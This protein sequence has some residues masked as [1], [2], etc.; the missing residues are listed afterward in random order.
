MYAVA[1][2]RPVVI[3]VLMAG[4]FVLGTGSASAQDGYEDETGEP[5]M[6]ATTSEDSLT[7][8]GPHQL[9]APADDRVVADT[10]SVASPR[11]AAAIPLGLAVLLLSVGGFAAMVTSIRASGR[12]VAPSS[13]A[14]TSQVTPAPSPRMME[15]T[16]ARRSAPAPAR[17][18]GP[19]L[20]WRTD[21][22]AVGR[23]SFTVLFVSTSNH[24][25]SNLAARTARE[26]I[27]SRFGDSL[28]QGFRISSAGTRANSA[29]PPHPSVMAE[30]AEPGSGAVS[31]QPAIQLTADM[32]EAADLV[33][34]ATR[35]HRTEV[36]RLR[37]SALGKTF[38]LVEYARLMAVVD[39]ES[40]P[41]DPFD[42]ARAAVSAAREKRGLIPPVPRADDDIADPL[43]SGRAGQRACASAIAT[44]LSAIVWLEPSPEGR[45][46]SQMRSTAKNRCRGNRCTSCGPRNGTGCSRVDRSSISTL[47][48]TGD[49][50]RRQR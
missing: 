31:R 27:R 21:Q 6:I 43:G 47:T 12:K 24:Y 7:V 41:V 46:W 1:F 35:K 33:L 18:D 14:P 5:G 13:S 50:S 32:I 40:L 8:A 22:C 28:A 45:R 2:A 34:T 42:R 17:V 48:G 25:R 10:R 19:D 11:R 4:M 16:P 26:L 23:S 39:P 15:E 36:V 29:Q 9:A 20:Q 49:W 37:P 38:T 30:L 44:A 3:A